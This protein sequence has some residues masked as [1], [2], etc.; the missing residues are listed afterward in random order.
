[1]FKVEIKNIKI[2]TKIGVSSIERKKEQLLHVSIKFNYKIN[3]KKNI[4]N[5]KSLKDYSKIIKFTKVYIKKSR[6]KTLEKLIL[7]SKK[8]LKKQ[9]HINNI[10]LKISKPDVAKKYGCSSISVS[11]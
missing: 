10:N 1:M 9:F 3:S 2:K 6:F 7:E 8:I 11:E 5:I 4:N